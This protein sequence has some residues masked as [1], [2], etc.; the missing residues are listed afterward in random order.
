MP[1]D[2]QDREFRKALLLRSRQLRRVATPAERALWDIVRDRKVAGLKF[3]RQQVLGRFIADFFCA[4]IKLVI[5]LDGGVHND[6][7]D[8][9]AVRRAVLEAGDLRVLRFHNEEVF[10]DPKSVVQRIA[11]LAAELRARKGS[12]A[13]NAKGPN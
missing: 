9:D 6:R 10:D 2:S 8:V 4:E 1:R 7:T 5:E 12:T 3:R 11:S 13:S